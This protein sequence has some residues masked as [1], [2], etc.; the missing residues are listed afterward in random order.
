MS[1]ICNETT[2]HM[3][4]RWRHLLQTFNQ[5][6][7]PHQIYKHLLAVCMTM[8]LLWKIAGA[9]LMRTGINQ[10]VLYNGP[11]KV[12]VIKFQ[13]VA[14]PNGLLASLHGSVEGEDMTV[15]RWQDLLL[16][17]LQQ[18]ATVPDGTALCMYAGTQH[19]LS[20]NN[21]KPIQGAHVNERL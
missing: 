20:D 19:T 15:Q 4:D 10:R 18:H 5:N 11:K 2:N 17:L 6:Y 14:A 12:H 9:L 7:F 21:Y 8:V 13:S 1:M 3:Y 16:P